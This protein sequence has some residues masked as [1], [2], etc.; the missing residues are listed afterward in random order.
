MLWLDLLRL[1]CKSIINIIDNAYNIKGRSYFF[2]CSTAGHCSVT[3]ITMTGLFLCQYF[4]FSHCSTVN[5][6]TPQTESSLSC[7]Y[8]S[9]LAGASSQSLYFEYGEFSSALSEQPR[10]VSELRAAEIEAKRLSVDR[11]QTCLRPPP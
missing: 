4:P 9:Q 7:P 6:G 8:S 2:Q 11:K 10:Q 3:F 1:K 5:L